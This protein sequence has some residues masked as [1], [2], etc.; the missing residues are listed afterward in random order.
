MVD[1]WCFCKHPGLRGEEKVDLV[2][3]LDDGKPPLELLQLTPHEDVAE[4]PW[5]ALFC[6]DILGNRPQVPTGTLGA[7]LGTKGTILSRPGRHILFCG[8]NP[9]A[10]KPQVERAAHCLRSFA[11]G[12]V[13]R[14]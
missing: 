12:R 1:L 14:G 7:D 4:P 10:A 13:V 2:A 8:S 5:A 11:S 3:E 6:E 9:R